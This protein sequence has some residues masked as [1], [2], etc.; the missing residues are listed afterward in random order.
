MH[1]IVFVFVRA[2]RVLTLSVVQLFLRGQSTQSLSSLSSSWDCG[3]ER[4]DP[5]GV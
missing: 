1:T 5:F 3:L 4:V 2:L